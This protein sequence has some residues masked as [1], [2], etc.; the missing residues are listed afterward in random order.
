[1]VLEG[2]VVRGRRLGRTLGFPTA[3]IALDQTLD[4]E[5]GVYRSRVEV[6][7]RLYWGVTNVGSN[8]TVGGG[9]R[10]VESYIL[11]FDRDIYGEH[12][13]VE[14]CELMRSEQRFESVEAL[15]TQVL[16][17]ISRVRE[18]VLM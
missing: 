13:R 1:M 3:N 4:I 10:H 9:E 12:I 6:D 2:I 5:S 7:G 8:P 15:Q 17:D 16:S 14:L 18:M 11:D